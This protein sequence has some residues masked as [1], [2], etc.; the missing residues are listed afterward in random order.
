MRRGVKP[1]ASDTFGSAPCARRASTVL[2]W[3]CLVA[4]IRAV[5]P[6]ASRALTSTCESSA[7]CTA[8]V[9]PDSAARHN[10]SGEAVLVDTATGFA[11]AA[12]GAAGVGVGATAVV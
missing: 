4:I 7:A 12:G 3:P 10:W 1:F 8:C 11:A 2:V 6:S 5:R 9:S